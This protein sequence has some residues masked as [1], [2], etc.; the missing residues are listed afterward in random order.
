MFVFVLV[1][2]DGGGVG[3]PT[4]IMLGG[5]ATD[6]TGCDAGCDGE[7][8]GSVGT[9]GSG[10]AAMESAPAAA[11]FRFGIDLAGRGDKRAERR[12]AAPVGKNDVR[13]GEAGVSGGLLLF[14][15]FDPA[16]ASFRLKTASSSS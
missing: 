15:P 4:V 6:W 1:V 16:D 8:G 12:L 13:V 10:G 9:V 5:C 11:A 7:G 14:P 3:M 2:A